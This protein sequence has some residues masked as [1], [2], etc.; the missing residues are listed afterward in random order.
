MKKIL[1]VLSIL[2]AFMASAYAQSNMAPD[3][4][5]K[6]LKGSTVKLSAYRGKPVFL[7]FTATWCPSCRA[8]LPR[9]AELY[10][11]YKTKGLIMLNIDIMESQEKVS[12][13]VKK[14]D[15]PF[16]VLLD[17]TG[18]VAQQYGVVGV[19]TKILIDSKGRIICQDCDT[20][21]DKLKQL[22]P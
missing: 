18:E 7:V 20:M 8:E 4:T 16:T 5:L 6:D 13:F 1:I 9:L 17:S 11:H 10:S 19:P 22:M 14:R 12:A 3:F 21:N 15:I 2:V